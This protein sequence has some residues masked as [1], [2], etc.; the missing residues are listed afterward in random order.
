MLKKFRIAFRIA[1]QHLGRVLSK[2]FEQKLPTKI[3]EKIL[4]ITK[5]KNKSVPVI[6]LPILILSVNDVMTV[7]KFIDF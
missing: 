6:I 7:K 5:N 4:I 1:S 2:K 3:A